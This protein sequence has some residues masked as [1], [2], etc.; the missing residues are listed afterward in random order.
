MLAV[1]RFVPKIR[2]ADPGPFDGVGYVLAAT[3]ICSAM[4]GAESIGVGL[5]PAW[6]EYGSWLLAAAA[7]LA[8]LRWARTR[9]KPV[10]DLSLF[11]VRTFRTNQTGG[12]LVRMTLGAMPFLLPLLL[13]GGLG[14]SPLKAG[15]VTVSGALGSLSARLGAQAALRR[16]GFRTTVIFTGVTCG[17][18]VGAAGFFRETTPMVVIVA[19]L[20]LGGFLRSNHLTSVSTLAFAD[21]PDTRV[22]Q[23]S[24]LTS[25]VQQMAQALGITVAGLALHIS[26]TITET[27]LL[28]S[29]DPRNFILPF[30]AV[31][32]MAMGASRTYLPLPA[33]AGEKLVGREG[34]RGQR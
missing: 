15:L 24:S 8:Y 25:V 11:K 20:A 32:L 1:L 33:N 21:I 34:V 14:W 28:G 31:G 22:S 7:A 4:V 30:A 6:V 13:Q 2:R 16:F 9:P 5:F 18:A 19:T 10:L 17:L 26:Q 23:A 12:S 3:A 29:L 27:S